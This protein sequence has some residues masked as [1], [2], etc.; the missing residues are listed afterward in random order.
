[1]GRGDLSWCRSRSPR[2]VPY[3]HRA[4]TSPQVVY[5]R[6]RLIVKREKRRQRDYR[7]KPPLLRQA[8]AYAIL[9]AANLNQGHAAGRTPG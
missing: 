9:S 4:I 1:M 2:K 8:P 6:W 3:G 5:T 7:A